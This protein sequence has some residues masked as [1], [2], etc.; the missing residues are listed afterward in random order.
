MYVRCRSLIRSRFVD[1]SP[2]RMSAWRFSPY[3]CLLVFSRLSLF[4]RRKGNR[5]RNCPMRTRIISFEVGITFLPLSPGSSHARYYR[6]RGGQLQAY[7]GIRT[8]VCITSQ[9]D[10]LYFP[11]AHHVI[12]LIPI[13]N[14]FTFLDGCPSCIMPRTS[15][16]TSLSI[17]SNIEIL[18]S[19]WVLSVRE[20]TFD[21]SLKGR[22]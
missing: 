17:R 5:W 9:G 1:A 11:Y 12:M 3:S 19:A 4:L 22:P 21:T 13:A 10:F 2:P 8:T 15:K 14:R 20:V 7:L 18:R 6:H 16:Y